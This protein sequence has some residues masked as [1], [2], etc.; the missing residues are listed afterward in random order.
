MQTP[1]PLEAIAARLAAAGSRGWWAIRR[2]RT[3]RRALAGRTAASALV[4][5]IVVSTRHDLHAATELRERWEQ[6]RTVLVATRAVGL[7]EAID[8]H[9]T[10]LQARPAGHVPDGA[11]GRRPPGRHA[12]SE[13]S[14]G[15]ILTEARVADQA[16]SVPAGRAAVAVSVQSPAPRLGRG[17]HLQLLAI[18]A[19][20]DLDGRGTGDSPARVV[21]H[22]AMALGSPE[23]TD[24]A[25]STLTVAVPQ[26]DVAEVAGAALVGP[27]AVVVPSDEP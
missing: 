13:L 26:A 22:D 8:E 27:L 24:A 23:E 2:S 10:E 14:R 5:V 17:D 3:A 9:N 6:Q 18:A 16:G 4:V 1:A 21:S 15:E 19:P 11:L 7:G 25:L 20:E 12:T